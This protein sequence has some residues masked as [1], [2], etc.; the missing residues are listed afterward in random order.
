MQLM[1][2]ETDGYQ[3]LLKD[4]PFLLFLFYVHIKIVLIRIVV[5]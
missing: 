1:L 4:F 2:T 5:T 3:N